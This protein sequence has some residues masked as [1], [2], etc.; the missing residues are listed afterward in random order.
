LRRA[1]NVELRPRE[2]LTDEEVSRLLEAARQRGGRYGFRDA[3]MILVTYLHGLRAA[4]VCALRWDQVHFAQAELHVARRKNGKP[5]VHTLRGS[6]LRALRRLKREQ[7]PA[8]AFVFT[9][10]RLAPMSTDGFRKLVSRV[11]EAAGFPF[12]AHPHMLRH[13]CGYELQKQN[14]P[15]RVIQAWLGHADIRHT[16]RYT[17]L[18]SVPFKDV[19]RAKD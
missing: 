13:A 4:E 12:P 3:T 5:S 8:S 7:T 10:E 2:Y 14:L 15:T 18:S 17:E 16:V 1:R 9:T 6:E 19:W 11:G